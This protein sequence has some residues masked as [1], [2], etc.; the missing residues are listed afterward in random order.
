M[1]RYKG[2]RVKIL[3]RFGQ[4]LP[5]LS[6]KSLDRR[7]FPPGQHGQSRRRKPSDYR[8]RLQ[9]KQKLR[10]NYGVSERQFRRYIKRASNSKMDTGLKL[11]LSLESR[12]D[13]VVFRA[14]FA[15]TIPAAR[16]LVNH[17]HVR[18]NGKK[19]NIPSY[20]V[21]PG[22][23]IGLR[24]RSKKIQVVLTCLEAPSISR[25]A[26]LDYNKEKLEATF[27]NVPTRE[28]IPVQI[29]ENLIVEFYSKMI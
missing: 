14:G 1:S 6:R 26:Y 17:G 23:V 13:S 11:L 27:K 20:E 19:V 7:P 4:Q 5:G 24:E 21:R 25:P 9:E 3:R 2:P 10:F 16:Q 18:I 8:I 28:D 29:Q 15:A 22:E 12:L